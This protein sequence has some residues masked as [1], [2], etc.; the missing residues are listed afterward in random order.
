[1]RILLRN[2]NSGL[3]MNSADR[4]E[5][6]DQACEFKSG[7]E[8]IT[9][10]VEHHL[11][12]VEIIYAFLNPEYNFCTEMAGLRPQAGASAKSYASSSSRRHSEKSALRTCQVPEVDST[13]KQLLTDSVGKLGE[14]FGQDEDGAG[15]KPEKQ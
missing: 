12:D 7:V 2:V 6:V 9:F 4:M 13:G 3:Y 15:A 11:S 5:D 14:R 10:A 8:A 1:M